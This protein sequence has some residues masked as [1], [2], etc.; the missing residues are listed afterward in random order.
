MKA[1][2]L[3]A[4]IVGVT[5]LLAGCTGPGDD[6]GYRELS[7]WAH[8]GRESER[9]TLEAQLR[10][11]EARHADVRIRLT[12]IPEGS[13]NGQ[14]QAAA[15]AGRL[16]DVLELDGPYLYSYA[17][18]GRLRALDDLLDERIQDDLLPSLIAQG[19]WR[20]RLFGVGT[21]DSGLGL[22]ADGRALSEAG[23]RVPEGPDDAWDDGEFRRVLR[24]LARRSGTG[25][26]LDLK[27]NYTDEWFTYAFSPLIQSAGAD[28]VHREDRRGASGM[29]DSPRAVRAMRE[30][31]DWITSGYVD[32]NLDD[33]AFVQGRVA[34]AWGGHWNYPAYRAALGDDLLL[35]P[36]PRFGPRMVTGQGSWQWA[37]TREA[38]DPDLA[39]SLLAFL[40]EP[41]EVLEMSR[42]NGAVPGTRRAVQRSPEYGPG[43]PLHLFVR[44]LDEGYAV[45]RPRTPAYPVIT[46]A[47]ARAF[48][49]I[50][51]GAPVEETLARAAG[52]IDREMAVNRFYPVVGAAEDSDEPTFTWRHDRVSG[53]NVGR[54]SGR[55]GGPCGAPCCRPEGRPTGEQGRPRV[56]VGDRPL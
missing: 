18:Q 30:I 31:Q 17:W 42:A 36:L 3:N 28:L 48:R 29:L 44:Q 7:V 40:L 1:S 51:H 33:A 8:A 52:H 2:P 4:W 39:A 45:P 9:V 41:E 49:D 50:R 19:T 11:F 21:F 54:P 46:A 14:V 35:L 16:P 24:A 32:P 22:W 10:R 53:W 26:V 43:G 13:Y 37:V 56:T 47:F 5:W 27:L 34:L 55:E 15:L 23:V 25:R 38:R 20:D 12:F 6:A